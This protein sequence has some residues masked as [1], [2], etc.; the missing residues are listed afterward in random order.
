MAQDMNDPTFKQLC[1]KLWND[2][3]PH[4]TIDRFHSKLAI[5][6][7]STFLGYADVTLGF[8]TRCG[9]V[10]QWKLRGLE[11]KLLNGKQH[12]DMPSER[13]SDGKYYPQ[14]FPKTPADRA[15]LT[16]MVFTDARVTE[17]IDSIPA[18]SEI[19]ASIDDE[20]ELGSVAASVDNPFDD[21]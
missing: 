17:T 6:P 11:V 19:G 9:H 1:G 10:A 4:T 5:H 14:F 7:K 12:L 3:A 20:P 16:T 21:E 13:S 8:M 15:V 18:A 2:F